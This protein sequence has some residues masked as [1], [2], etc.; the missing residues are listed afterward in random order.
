MIVLGLVLVIGALA[1]GELRSR[2]QTGTASTTV[3]NYRATASVEDRP[4]PDFEMPRL[5]GGEP[6]AVRDLRGQVVVLNFWASWCGPCRREAPAL[7]RAWLDLRDRGVQ[8]LGVNYRD[9]EAAAQAFV[10]EF[11][12]T[13][14]SVFDPAGELAFSYEVVGFPTTFVIAADGTIVYRFVGYLDEPVLRSAV[15][16]A[17]LGGS[18]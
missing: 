14:P 11:R 3:A 13:Y 18:G 15:D 10:D 6:V 8:F 2:N 5:G 16:D 9:D 7:E 1:V 4:A 17:L 12:L